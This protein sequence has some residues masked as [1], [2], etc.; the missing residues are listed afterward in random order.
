[1]DPSLTLHSPTPSPSPSPSPAPPSVVDTTSAP[2]DRIPVLIVGAGPVGIL[3]AVLLTKMGIPVRIIERE[4]DI[5]RQSRAL[6]VH[7]RTLEILAMM[8]DGLIDKFLAV[9]RTIPWAHLYY[10]SQYKCAVP[11][12]D[13]EKT[14]KSRFKGELFLEQEQTCELLL[15]ELNAMGVKIEFGWEL[16]E[17]K[18]VQ[19]DDDE[20]SSK[21]SCHVRTI[22]RQKKL[23]SEEMATTTTNNEGQV[24][25]VLSEY[26]IGTDGGRSTV[27]HQV[28][29]PFPGRTLLYK[30]LMF[31]GTLETNLGTE[32]IMQVQMAVTGINRKTFLLFHIRDN[33]YR[34]LVDV[35]DFTSEDDDLESINRSL[36]VQDFEAA[37]LGCFHPGGTTVFKVTETY[38]LNCLRTNER[39]AERYI[40]QGRIILAG[41]AAHVHSPAGGQGMN[42]GLQDAHNLA[43]K[44]GLVLN[45]LAPL[46]LLQSYE[47]ERTVIADEVIALSSSLL[48]LSRDGGVLYHWAKRAL[49]E[50]LPWMMKVT[51]SFIPIEATMLKVHY[52]ENEINQVVVPE[53]QKKEGQQKKKNNKKERMTFD[54]GGP[55]ADG[56]LLW[57]EDEKKES[58]H[59]HA[60]VGSELASID[61]S[62]AAAA[63]GGGADREL[64]KSFVHELM[65]GVGKFHILVF[66]GDQLSPVS[67]DNNSIEEAQEVLAKDMV[68]HVGQWRKR[69][70]WKTQ[71]N[72]KTINAA[73]AATQAQDDD[74][75]DDKQNK[76]DSQD[77]QL[78]KVHVIASTNAISNGLVWFGKLLCERTRGDGKLFWD[79]AGVVHERYGVVPTAAAGASAAAGAG[80]KR[81]AIVV[82]RPDSYIGFR[83][84]GIDQDAWN[85]VGDYFGRILV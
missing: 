32:E 54:V 79:F 85:D 6:S 63:G 51:T 37:V 47:S 53:D 36:T 14:T 4:L 60:A 72:K 9:G 3:E 11:M 78:F 23:T 13:D 40:H 16:V 45:Q 81:G 35:D 10:G 41:D 66:A 67:S 57:F 31:D 59:R 25:V 82:V 38:W 83:V 8:G 21:S 1:M 30:S 55:A 50:F 64:C 46:S 65:V 24:R 42:T 69:W 62:P 22:I 49:L 43:W 7:P 77:D 2:V 80:N 18:V 29:I 12:G 73:V 19:E 61:G 74:D 44:L 75:D 58:T 56:P 52:P 84:E 27:R 20:E 39:R 33:H 76:G 34:A 48:D 17:T 71:E 26:L 15:Q 5:C 68:T 70:F 28:K